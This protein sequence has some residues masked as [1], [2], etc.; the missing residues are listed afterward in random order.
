MLTNQRSQLQKNSA[1]LR[2]ALIILFLFLLVPVLLLLSFAP[3]F[4]SHGFGYANRRAVNKKSF[5]A[6]D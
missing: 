3:F 5:E 1:P 6:L 2:L 4:N